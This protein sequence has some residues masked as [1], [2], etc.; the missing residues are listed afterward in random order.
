LQP[1]EPIPAFEGEVCPRKTGKVTRG[2]L[3]KPL[4]FRPAASL[5][6]FERKTAKNGRRHLF[7]PRSS[8]VFERQ[9]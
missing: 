3:S 1:A 6:H 4:S 8:R 9:I 5:E 2:N 7:R